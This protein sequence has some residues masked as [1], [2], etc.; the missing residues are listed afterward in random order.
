[1]DYTKGCVV[2]PQVDIW[3]EENEEDGDGDGD[4]EELLVKSGD[5]IQKLLSEMKTQEE[6]PRAHY[7][8]YC[9]HCGMGPIGLE[10]PVGLENPDVLD[11][12]ESDSCYDC[13]HYR[14]EYCNVLPIASGNMGNQNSPKDSH[15]SEEN[16]LVLSEQ[17]L[18]VFTD[19][20][21]D[22]SNSSGNGYAGYL[23]GLSLG[24]VLQAGSPSTPGLTV[25][26][27][28][29]PSPGEDDEEQRAGPRVVEERIK[30]KKSE[31][32][33]QLAHAWHKRWK[34]KNPEEGGHLF[35]TSI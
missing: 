26:S 14:C 3:C 28:A 12:K 16:G 23:L 9:C 22:C 8:W 31:C 4:G 18:A 20:H 30:V 35:H 27:A 13:S 19:M 15:G 10:G 21:S 5:V 2:G 34:R 33:L 1:M 32:L 11:A 29:S 7:N 24:E 6:V 17:S 25:S